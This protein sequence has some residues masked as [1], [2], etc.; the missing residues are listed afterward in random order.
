MFFGGFYTERAICS[1]NLLGL[2]MKMFIK[3]YLLQLFIIVSMFSRIGSV[4]TGSLSLSNQDML[5]YFGRVLK[6]PEYFGGKASSNIPYPAAL[7]DSQ[8]FLRTI[9][10]V[11]DSYKTI[12]QYQHSPA[13]EKLWL[14]DHGG[15]P[16]FSSTKNIDGSCGEVNGYIQKLMLPVGAE[17]IVFGDLH[18]SMHAFA[19]MLLKLV[20]TGYLD[21]HLRLVK[22]NTYMMFLGDFTDYGFDGVGTLWTAFYLRAVNPSRVFLCRGNHEDRCLNEHPRFNFAGEVRSKYELSQA[23]NMLNAVYDLYEYL[24]FAIFLCI[25]GSTKFGYA[26]CCH[27]GIEP[28]AC[29]TIRRLLTDKKAFF[30]KLPAASFVDGCTGLNWSDGTGYDHVPLHAPSPRGVGVVSSI[31]GLR[32]YMDDLSIELFLRGH[33]DCDNSFKMLMRGVK[34]P[35][36][37]F[38]RNQNVLGEMSPLKNQIEQLITDPMA[39]Y[40]SGFRLADLPKNKDGKWVIAPFITVTNASAAKM[41]DDEGFCILTLG[42]TW[43]E[44]TVRAYVVPAPYEVR[45]IL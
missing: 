17:V 25:E 39:L 37:F 31:D 36:Y 3:T 44:S 4:P 8:D 5:D 43:A 22:P 14:P 15:K 33:Q 7:I 12:D 6:T 20:D 13:S 41:N 23:K 18:G 40:T 19:R 24:P 2:F 34:D 35:A 11:V 28:R 16:V 21:Q 38:T 9:S 30:A 1:R 27:G 45:F 29:E 10:I 32:E 26:Q 42:K